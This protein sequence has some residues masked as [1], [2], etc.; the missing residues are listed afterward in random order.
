M[1]VHT[2]VLGLQKKKRNSWPPTALSLG[3]QRL[4]YFETRMLAAA[5]DTLG[6]Y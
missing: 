5:G 4:A 1:D 2:T 3:V 6:N